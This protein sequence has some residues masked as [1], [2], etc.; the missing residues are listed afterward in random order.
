MRQ[1]SSFSQLASLPAAG[2][3]SSHSVPH[4][5]ARLPLEMQPVMRSRWKSSFSA[6]LQP[7]LSMEKGCQCTRQW[8]KLQ[9]VLPSRNDGASPSRAGCSCLQWHQKSLGFLQAADTHSS[10]EH[11]QVFKVL[12]DGNC[13]G[14]KKSETRCF[15]LW[16][17][18]IHGGVG[19]LGKGGEER[20]KRP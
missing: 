7:D 10:V 18:H 9:I 1:D 4:S 8:D 5:G 11:W 2:V 20:E 13:G 3:A 16:L 6:T 14:E 17:L 12:S 15:S 19:G